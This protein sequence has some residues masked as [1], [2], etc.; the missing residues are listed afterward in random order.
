MCYHLLLLKK[1]GFI[2]KNC[3]AKHNFCFPVRYVS[4]NVLTEGGL[5]Y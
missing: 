5:Y 2:V 3:C 1:I 4:T